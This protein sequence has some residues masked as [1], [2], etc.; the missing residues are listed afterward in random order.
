MVFFMVINVI[1]VFFY[2]F[3]WFLMKIMVIFFIYPSNYDVFIFFTDF[4]RVFAVMKCFKITFLKN[5]F[6]F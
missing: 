6:N 2:Y 4:F 3:F 5:F 1:F